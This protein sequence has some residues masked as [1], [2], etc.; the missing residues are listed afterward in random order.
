M[1]DRLKLSTKSEDKIEGRQLQLWISSK[2]TNFCNM[3]GNFRFLFQWTV[4]WTRRN[5]RHGNG[6]IIAFRCWCES[7][8][9]NFCC[10]SKDDRRFRL[11]KLRNIGIIALQQPCFTA[12][13]KANG[14]F[15]LWNLAVGA[16]RK[17]I[18]CENECALPWCLILIKGV[19]TFYPA[20]LLQTRAFM[21][22]LPEQAFWW[23]NDWMTSF[24]FISVLCG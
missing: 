21:S 1:A 14:S 6:N 22:C 23:E 24:A 17:S 11:G 15:D 13:Q 8:K 7:S 20:H 12:D 19:S 9:R 10:D 16:L 4:L 5:S 2:R 18:L 3:S